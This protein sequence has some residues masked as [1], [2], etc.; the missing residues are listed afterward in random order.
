MYFLLFKI[1]L[2]G[3]TL[4]C[5]WKCFSHRTNQYS[6]I[7][8][9]FENLCVFLCVWERER[10]RN[11]ERGRGMVIWM[12]EDRSKAKVITYSLKEQHTRG[13]CS[14]PSV[15]NVETTAF[16][17]LYKYKQSTITRHN[18]MCQHF[19]ALTASG[20]KLGASSVRLLSHF[21]HKD[22]YGANGTTFCNELSYMR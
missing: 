11:W 16:H 12:L 4:E 8:M 6:C 3:G 22:G 9:L 7:N 18:V 21:K 19:T 14:D 1:N 13:H 2:S 5:V 15:L 20:R 10:E 17:H